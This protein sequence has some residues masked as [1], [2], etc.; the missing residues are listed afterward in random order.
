M[1]NG[2]ARRRLIWHGMFLFLLGLV[3]GFAEQHFKNERMGLAG[4]LEGVMNGIFL[5]ALGS[6]WSEVHLSPRGQ[7][8]AYWTALYGTYVNWATTILAALFGTAA[9]SPITASG[10]TGQPWQETLVTLA[11]VTVGLAMVS[12]AISV[13]VGLRRT[14]NP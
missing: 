4:H 1:N 6:V 3:T 12:C 2:D 10:Q 13:L 7:S 9:L 5:I 11:F 8:T 14:S